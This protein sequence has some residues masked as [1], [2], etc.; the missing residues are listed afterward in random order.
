[1][2]RFASLASLSGR[3]QKLPRYWPRLVDLPGRCS[4]LPDRRSSSS[5]GCNQYRLTHA[6]GLQQDWKVWDSN[7]FVSSIESQFVFA[8]INPDHSEFSNTVGDCGPDRLLELH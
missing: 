8:E 3:P 5:L 2:P 6:A 1:M 7:L 4:H